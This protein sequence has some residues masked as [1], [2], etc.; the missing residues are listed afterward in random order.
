MGWGLS[1]WADDW[2]TE[3]LSGGASRKKKKVQS[4]ADQVSGGHGALDGCC[5]LLNNNDF[6]HNTASLL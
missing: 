5:I 4:E 2:A 1:D 3:Q 6:M